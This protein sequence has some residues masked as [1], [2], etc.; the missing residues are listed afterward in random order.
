MDEESIPRAARPDEDE[1]FEIL[2][3]TPVS[4]WK[5][6]SILIENVLRKWEI[7]DGSTG[8]FDDARVNIDQQNASSTASFVVK[9]ILTLEEYSYAL[10]Y[11]YHPVNAKERKEHEEMYV[12]ESW[13]GEREKCGFLPLSYP[14]YHTTTAQLKFHPIHHWT[15][16]SHILIVTPVSISGLFS[17]GV[18]DESNNID[19]HTADRLLH[20]FA[21]AFKKVNCHIPVFVPVGQA[22]KSV[23]GGLML[24]KEKDFELRFN[25]TY[26]PF[27][28]KQYST[29]DGLIE[30]MQKP[31]NGALEQSTQLSSDTDDSD[32][33]STDD[34][35]LSAIYTYSLEEFPADDR[36]SSK[37]S[38]GEEEDSG[39]IDWDRRSYISNELGPAILQFG[40]M[41]DPL[42]SL[43][44]TVLYTGKLEN[45]PRDDETRLFHPETK[46]SSWYLSCEFN[47]EERNTSMLTM[48]LKKAVGSWIGDTLTARYVHSQDYGNLSLNSD[49][50]AFRSISIFGATII[51]AVNAAGSVPGA[52][53]MVD[54]SDIECMIQELFN[55]EKTSNS[56]Q[57]SN[58]F[59]AEY[60]RC[61]RN[62]AI[63]IFTPSALGLHFKPATTVP[64]KSLVWNLLLQ[65]LSSISPS[66][67]STHSA[68]AIG[69]LKILWSEFNKQVKY[70]WEESIPLP[71]VDIGCKSDSNPSGRLE[72]SETSEESNETIDLRFN[73]IHQKLAMINCCILRRNRRK[74]RYPPS[75]NAKSVKKTKAIPNEPVDRSVT[76][77]AVKSLMSSFS[78][79]KTWYGNQRSGKLERIFDWLTVDNTSGKPTPEDL[80]EKHHTDSNE[81]YD[82]VFYDTIEDANEDIEVEDMERGNQA[83]N[84]LVDSFVQLS[85][86]EPKVLEEESESEQDSGEEEPFELEENSREG[87]SHPSKDLLLLDTQ[88]IMWI[89]E[90]QEPE[91]MTEDM[92]LKRAQAFEDLGTSEEGASERARL[93]CAQLKSDME[94]FKAANPGCTLSDFVRW[95][96]PRDWVIEEGADI[97]DPE[98]GKLSARMVKEGNFWQELWKTAKRIPA[99]RQKPIFDYESE[100]EEALAYLEQLSVYELFGELLPTILLV[101]YDVL[102]AHPI[103]FKIEPIALALSVLGKQ[104]TAYSWEDTDPELASLANILDSFN[105]VELLMGRGVSLLKK[106]NDHYE[107]VEWLITLTESKVNEGA[108]KSTIYRCFAGIDESCTPIS[109]EYV[110]Q[111]LKDPQTHKQKT[112]QRM[113]ILVKEDEFRLMET[114]RITK[115]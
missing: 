17:P 74:G 112:S 53:T 59:H 22:W 10:S 87:Q 88:E 73:L 65:L 55:E 40:P 72:Q 63:Q 80:T 29:L 49:T 98:K 2:D 18:S 66:P 28:P 106:L 109:K 60:I 51:D 78:D 104:L 103:A 25:T 61:E 113:Y 108:E 39:T 90:T 45:F 24:G 94:A 115:K 75:D 31:S 9:E 21:M 7:S 35:E 37:L 50:R 76:E 97:N 70:H 14:R 110:V 15:G 57:T 6:F 114:T 79:I 42:E 36:R 64:Y 81:D 111:P 1:F 5:R 16:L 99:Y 32:S 46:S 12:R 48:V 26:V 8:V 33:A 44:L 95:H 67:M 30:L 56:P 47:E 85:P 54:S 86:D 27:V 82:E 19:A 38:L 20:A 100:A 101:A 11:H 69:L 92:L 58:P 77:S 43:Q 3:Y 102:T 84:A 107:L 91:I 4:Y 105:E 13:P 34:I 23:Y 68:T 62:P 89:P 41:T 83:G 71:N 96:S 93:Q 52:L